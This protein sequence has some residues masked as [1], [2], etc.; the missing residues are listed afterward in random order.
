MN[1]KNINLRKYAIVN[2][3]CKNDTGCCVSITCNNMNKQMN[4][5][6]IKQNADAKII[7]SRYE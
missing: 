6:K 1:K 2:S 3:I 5:L 7:K 4:K